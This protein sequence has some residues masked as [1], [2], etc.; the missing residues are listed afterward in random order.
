[1]VYVQRCKVA[2]LRSASLYAGTE[3]SSSMCSITSQYDVS[4]RFRLISWLNS[5]MVLF[6]FFSDL[7]TRLVTSLRLRSSICVAMLFL[8]DAIVSSNES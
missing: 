7:F 5:L 3:S 1:M 6:L 8:S 2:F 4:S